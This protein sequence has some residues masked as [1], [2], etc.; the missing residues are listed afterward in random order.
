MRGIRKILFAPVRPVA[1]SASYKKSLAAAT[2]LTYG[3]LE[4]N[5]SLLFF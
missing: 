1:A 5:F 4:L 3:F 2:D